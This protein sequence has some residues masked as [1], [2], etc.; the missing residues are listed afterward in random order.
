MKTLKRTIKSRFDSAQRDK[1]ITR[2]LK[3]IN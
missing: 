1:T 3:I 2:R